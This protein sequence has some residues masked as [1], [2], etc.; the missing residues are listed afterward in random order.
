MGFSPRIRWPNVARLA[1]GTIACA[2]LLLTLPGL[3]RRPKPPPLEADIGLVPASSSPAESV[4]AS[5]RHP[6]RRRRPRPSPER[7]GR[8]RRPGPATRASHPDHPLHGQTDHAL[9]APT[10]DA[11]SPPP[12]SPPAP[13]GS[14]PEAPPPVPSP[15]PDPA[16]A[17][18]H[19]SEFGFER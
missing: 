16:P 14:P 4:F 12:P 1:L 17:P 19:P 13:A 5:R 8:A 15:P 18:D 2:A 7:R 10:A 3:I 6:E 9:G 11:I